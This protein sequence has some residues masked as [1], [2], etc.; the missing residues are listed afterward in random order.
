MWPD[1]ASLAAENGFLC[2]PAVVTLDLMCAEPKYGPQ[3]VL[4]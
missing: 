1:L 3:V 2:S 4:G